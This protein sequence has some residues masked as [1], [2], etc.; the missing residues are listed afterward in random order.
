MDDQGDDRVGYGKPPKATRFVKGQSGNPKGRP[1]HEK[2]LRALFTKIMRERVTVPT[3]DGEI[4]MAGTELVLIQL[5]NR[6]IKGDSRASAQ[7]L[8]LMITI[9]GI[10]DPEDQRRNLSKEDDEILRE[11]LRALSGQPNA[12]T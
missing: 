4:R 2:T 10:G 9:F 12:K 11:A 5:R 6:A 3:S 8:N 7:L 1:K